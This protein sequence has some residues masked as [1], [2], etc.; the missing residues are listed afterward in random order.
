[1]SIA[2]GIVIVLV[3]PIF[4]IPDVTD[5]TSIRFWGPWAA[6]AI[7]LGGAAVTALAF[8]RPRGRLVLFAGSAIT[9]IV[10]A[11]ALARVSPVVAA[12]LHPAGSTQA[13]AGVTEPASST[14]GQ[15]G[16]SDVPVGPVMTPPAELLT[17]SPEDRTAWTSAEADAAS[18]LR[19]LT[20]ENDIIVT[21]ETTSFLVPALA[22]RLTYLSGAPYQGLYGSK[23]TVAGIPDRI[24]T[25]LAFTR[26]LDADAYARLCKAGVTWGWIALDGTPLRSWEPYA[27]TE[28]ENDAVAVIRF[29]RGACE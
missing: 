14:A 26:A 5:T 3:V 1:V 4:W 8:G 20:G 27:A 12:R 15:T 11:G 7:A 13:T 18:A 9:A 28:F 10:V 25:S 24:A 29:N 16:V 23:A 19:D 21:N 17:G 22:G 6:Y 2:C